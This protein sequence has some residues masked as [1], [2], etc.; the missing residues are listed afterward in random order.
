MA[1]WYHFSLTVWLR[2]KVSGDA[3]QLLEELQEHL[4]HDYSVSELKLIEAE[5]TEL[6]DGAPGELE[7]SFQ[8]DMSFNESQVEFGDPTEE[9][10][11]ELDNEL[12]NYVASKFPLTHLETLGDALTT[13]FLGESDDDTPESAL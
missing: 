12:T 7:F 13:F 3:S 11:D 9:A 2:L 4:A 8:L 10:I 1:K 6:A 5:F